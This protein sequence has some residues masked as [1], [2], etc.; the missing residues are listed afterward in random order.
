[1]MFLCFPFKDGDFLDSRGRLLQVSTIANHI[2]MVYA[3][4]H[5][6]YVERLSFDTKGKDFDG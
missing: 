2:S 3:Q 5:G 6:F 4:I 1:M